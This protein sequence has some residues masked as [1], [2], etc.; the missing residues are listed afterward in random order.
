MVIFTE[1]DFYG[2]GSY[3]PVRPFKHVGIYCNNTTGNVIEV[4]FSDGS[5]AKFTL[6]NYSTRSWSTENIRY[7]KVVSG[8]VRPLVDETSFGTLR[9]LKSMIF[10][11]IPVDL[12]SQV[13][14]LTQN[15]LMR[16]L[17]LIAPTRETAPLTAPLL[18][19]S[20][21]AAGTGT[22]TFLASTTYNGSLA[23]IQMAIS[24]DALGTSPHASYIQILDSAG[25]IVAMIKGAVNSPFFGKIQLQS[26]GQY[27]YKYLNGDSVAHWFFLSAY[28]VI[29]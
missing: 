19:E 23:Y 2:P 27:T 17:E 10:G 6:D 28:V 11:T 7:I 9:E 26:I 8:S 22:G 13:I 25:N 29:P 4:G 12:G 20:V 1:G 18:D 24:D 16:D 5:V 21:A 3:L 15:A 14:P